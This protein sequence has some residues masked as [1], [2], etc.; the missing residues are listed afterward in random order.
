MEP[1]PRETRRNRL[2]P[3]KTGSETGRAIVIEP[4]LRSRA[5]TGLASATAEG[6]RAP[7]A[8]LEEAVGRSGARLS[9]SELVRT[10]RDKLGD[11]LTQDASRGNDRGI[12]ALVEWARQSVG[13]EQDA[14]GH[15]LPTRVQKQTIQQ[16]PGQERG[17]SAQPVEQGRGYGIS[18]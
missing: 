17:P 13:Y 1:Q 5:T 11:G 8:R 10:M 2:S 14:D 18:W 4:G 15:A 6:K 16:A 7:S 12:R 9:A 3:T